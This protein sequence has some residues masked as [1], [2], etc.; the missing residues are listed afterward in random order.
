MSGTQSFKVKV[1][2]T[3]YP[4]VSDE[5]TFT[6]LV[7]STCIPTSVTVESYAPNPSI[8]ECYVGDQCMTDSFTL[9]TPSESQCLLTHATSVAPVLIN[10]V[11]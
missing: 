8:V 7:L 2:Y 10:I 5:K 1:H 9:A 3:D 4:T 11:Y 6:V